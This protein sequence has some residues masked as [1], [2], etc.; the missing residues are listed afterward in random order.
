[1]KNLFFCI[2]FATVMNS[3][4]FSQSEKSDQS[5]VYLYD[6]S[7][8]IGEILSEDI[9]E[10]TLQTVAL[11]TI[12]IN[13]AY[14]KK[15]IAGP[16]ILLTKNGKYHKTSPYFLTADWMAGSSPR[17]DGIGLF[18]IIAG[19][20]IKTRTEVGLGLG[21]TTASSRANELWRD[22]SFL[23]VFAYGK[24]YLNDKTI[25]PFADLK[26]GWSSATGNTWSG[27]YSGGLFLN[28]GIGIQ[29][30]NRKK[31]KWSF[32]LS[33]TI[34]QTSG[35]DNIGWAFDNNPGLGN[36]QGTT[37]DYNIWLNRTTFGIGIHF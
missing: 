12:T 37:I 19:Q 9:F 17:G 2:L 36:N 1:M 14:I 32:R 21:I 33:Q 3:Y 34:Q 35:R 4:C 31:M 13:K 23:N 10:I 5:Y 25:R 6:G 20:R 27:E 7:V 22:Q 24:Q 16:N 26:V 29:I 11:K 15:T 8:Y 30:A 28:P 18:S